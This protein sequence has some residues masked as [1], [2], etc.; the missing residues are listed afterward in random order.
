MS[1]SIDRIQYR[2]LSREQYTTRARESK[3][4]R[5]FLGQTPECR[6]ESKPYLRLNLN[7][8]E[9]S[10]DKNIFLSGPQNQQNIMLTVFPYSL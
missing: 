8:A 1:L 7:E 4:Q 5:L 10:G 2:H 9:I 6:M 3:V